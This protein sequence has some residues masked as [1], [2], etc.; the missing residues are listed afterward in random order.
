MN[1]VGD[2][3]RV[4][5]VVALSDTDSFSQSEHICLIYD[6]YGE[7]G[8]DIYLFRGKSSGEDIYLFRGKSSPFL[9]TSVNLEQLDGK[10]RARR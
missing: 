1:F 10:G 3:N 2:N 5:E 4:F 7:E 9:S 8:E 6:A